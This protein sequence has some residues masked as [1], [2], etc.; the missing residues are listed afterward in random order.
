[1]RLVF[2]E[3]EFSLWSRSIGEESSHPLPESSG[4][5]WQELYHKRAVVDYEAFM[6]VM[7][8]KQP[9]IQQ[10][11][12]EITQETIANNRKKLYSIIETILLCGRQNIALRGHRDSSTDLE[13]NSDGNFWAL[14]Q[15]RVLAGDTVLGEKA[16]RN[17]MYTMTF[18]V[19]M[20]STKLLPK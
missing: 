9:S 16:P 15:F 3:C 6:K 17:A 18:L 14:L 13:R 1:M 10:Q 19:I 8:Q 2:E 20:C 4:V 7:T 11:L 12:R 5:A